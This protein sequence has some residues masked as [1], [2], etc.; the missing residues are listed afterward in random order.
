MT[1]SFWRRFFLCA[2]VGEGEGPLE[3]VEGLRVL[4]APNKMT[5]HSSGLFR[6]GLR[7]VVGVMLV[8]FGKGFT[9][10]WG[11]GS[12]FVG[13]GGVLVIVGR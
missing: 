8:W 2:E 9:G 13:S 4:R 3:Q 12:F 1:V 11:C 7:Q 10:W 5:L 6:S